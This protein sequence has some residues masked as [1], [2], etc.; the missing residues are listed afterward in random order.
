MWTYAAAYLVAVNALTFAMFALDKAWARRGGWRVAEATLLNLAFAGGSP[1][2][3]AAQQ[4]LRHKTRKEP[5]R[6][7]L[8]VICGVQAV[9]VIAAAAWFGSR[10]A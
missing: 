2:A 7:R 6:T 10:Q 4:L 3:V 9:T 5:F 1:A 8:F